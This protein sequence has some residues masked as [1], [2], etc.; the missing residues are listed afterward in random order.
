MTWLRRLFSK[1]D[2]PLTPEQIATIQKVTNVLSARRGYWLA[3]TTQDGVEVSDPNYVRQFLGTDLANLKCKNIKFPPFKHTQVIVEA[4]LMD[5]AN[6]HVARIPLRA[7]VT[8]TANTTI[9]FNADK[10]VIA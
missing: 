3:L 5:S 7:Q 8:I 9:H 10:L 2:P 1:A 6:R 4:A